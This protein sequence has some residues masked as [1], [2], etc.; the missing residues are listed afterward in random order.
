[1]NLNKKGLKIRMNLYNK[2]LNL[3]MN[4]NKKRIKFNNEFIQK[5]C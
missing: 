5:K 4:L 3:W 2:G 1:M